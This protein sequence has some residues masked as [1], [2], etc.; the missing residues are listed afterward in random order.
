MSS[1]VPIN[2]ATGLLRVAVGAVF[3]AHGS[4][5]LFGWFG[6]GGI[7]G[8]GRGMHMMGFRP[9][10]RHATIAGLIETGGGAA[11][12]LGLATPAA[13]ASTAIAMG[14]AAGAQASNG[15]FASKNGLEY[16]AVLGLAA[17]SFALGGAGHF[18]LDAATGRLLDKGWMR[19]LGLIA[20]PIAIA[21]QLGRRHATLK[22][23]LELA[24]D[25]DSATN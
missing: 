3:I 19:A 9:G 25:E 15:F 16:P 11:L 8:V 4:Q 1:N 21:V 17:A 18:S 7:A 14:V 13:G 2:L 20:I 24:H 5:K 6:G 12:A 10:E 22:N 23:E